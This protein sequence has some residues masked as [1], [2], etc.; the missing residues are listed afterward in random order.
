MTNGCR[1]ILCICASSHLQI[2]NVLN[3]KKKNNVINFLFSATR[4]A[5]I[6][7]G[8]GTIK[9]RVEPSFALSD[10][11]G[12]FST[13]FHLS[14]A[15]DFSFSCCRYQVVVSFRNSVACRNG[16]RNVG[17]ILRKDFAAVT[18]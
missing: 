4:D 12:S 13:A 10:F 15:V 16:C 9:P 18:F 5:G 3:R 1:F 11:I 2:P 7:T 17:P 8:T 14:A 6:R